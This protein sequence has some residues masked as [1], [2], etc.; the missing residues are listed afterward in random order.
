MSRSGVPRR[1]FLGAMTSAGAAALA[2]IPLARVAEAAMIA[3]PRTPMPGP[4]APLRLGVASY[5][6]R[7]F[8]LDK[9]LEM[10]RAL[11]TPYVN[12]K[13]VHLPYEA[14]SSE[15]ASLRRQIEGAGFQ[16]VG[17]GTITFSKDTDEDVA[18][19]F[20]YARAAGIPLIV[21][22]G[23]PAVLPRLETF[24]RRYDI[25][26][27]IHNHGPE[28]P[29]FPSPYDVLKHVKD[30]D[31]RLGLCID[32]GH[33]ARTGTDVVQA[34]VDAG[35][36]LLDMHAKDLRDPMA[37]ASQCIVGEGALPIPEIFRALQTIRYP[38]LVNLEYEIDA[39]DPL[40][41]MKQSFAYMR[42]VLAGMAAPPARTT[43]GT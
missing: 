18:R 3:P 30:M 34:I 17:G 5:S 22:T 16:I 28:D 8:P 1:T 29:H 21:G 31:P 43:S 24:V 32:I 40:P 42:G 36:R 4:P 9:A 33:T 35:P 37:K 41:G 38:G 15:L 14:S 12:F 2:A 6:L 11:R 39:D 26:V 20:E 10:M 7:K 27:A 23:A 13:S 25:K 19:Y